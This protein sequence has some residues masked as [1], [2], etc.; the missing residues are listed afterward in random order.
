MA[1]EALQSISGR[2]PQVVQHVGVIEHVEFSV[3]N[4]GDPRPVSA[5]GQGAIRKEALDGPTGESLNRHD[6]RRVYPMQV[7][8]TGRDV[9][10]KIAYGRIPALEDFH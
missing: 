3:R 7:W 9:G 10:A 2:R 1:L 5:A 4:P 8:S 6:S